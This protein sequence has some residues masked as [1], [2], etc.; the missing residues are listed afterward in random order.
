[1]ST[2][3]GLAVSSKIEALRSKLTAFASVPEGVGTWNADLQRRD[4]GG[5]VSEMETKRPVMQMKMSIPR[6]SPSKSVARTWTPTHDPGGDAGEDS[7]WNIS[8]V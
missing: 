7:A 8:N 6:V 2:L 5:R 1:M 4:Y 3:Y